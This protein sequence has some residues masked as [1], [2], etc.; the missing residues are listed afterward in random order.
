MG[1]FEAALFLEDVSK[2]RTRHAMCWYVWI[3]AVFWF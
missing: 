1:K 2:Q 3:R